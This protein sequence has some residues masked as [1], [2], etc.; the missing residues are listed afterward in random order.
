MTVF[1]QIKKF[2]IE[3][4]AEFVRCIMDNDDDVEVACYGCIH[5][6]THH[7]DPQ[8]K[9]TGLYECDGCCWEGIGLDLIKW[10]NAELPKEEA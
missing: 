8:N 4:M 10:L 5:Y 6:G 1:E 3:E 2:S 9:G 7:S